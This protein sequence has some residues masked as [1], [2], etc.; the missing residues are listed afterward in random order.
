LNFAIIARVLFFVVKGINRLKQQE[1]AAPAAKPAA[2]Q[3][4]LLEEIRDLLARK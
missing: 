2:R 3:E 1:A 4:V